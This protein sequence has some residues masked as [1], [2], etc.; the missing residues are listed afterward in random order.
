MKDSAKSVRVF[1]PNTI[2]L[3][4]SGGGAVQDVGLWPLAC[5]DCGFESRQGHGC[6]SLVNVVCCTGT[7][8]CEGPIPRPGE[9]YRMCTCP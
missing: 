5:W 8:L 6:L 7:G 4:D 2:K 1:I 9:S 3:A